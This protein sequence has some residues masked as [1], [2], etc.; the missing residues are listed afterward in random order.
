VYYAGRARYEEL[1]HAGVRIYEYGPAMMHAKTIVADGMWSTVGS[2]N[3]DN[4]SLALNIEANLLT[5]D[6]GLGAQL[7]SLFLDDLR[8]SQEITLPLF[9]KRPLWQRLFE[10]GANLLSRVL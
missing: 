8:H 1:L 4:R 2:M 10:T 6:A 3:F 5:V 7:D 9:E